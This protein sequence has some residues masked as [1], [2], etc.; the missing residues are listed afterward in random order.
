[1]NI[2]YVMRKCT[3]CGKW[4]VA[5]TVNFHRQKTGK[6]GLTSR[7]KECEKKLKKQWNEAN[8]EYY[9]QYRENNK[10]KIAIQK[11]EYRERNKEKIAAQQKERYEQNKDKILACNKKW[12][13]QNKDKVKEYR[14]EYA[15]LHKDEIRR[16]IANKI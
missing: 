6:Y 3:K 13:E 8:P 5:S 4:L 16:N 9:K 11:K 2:P 12:K 14:K 7:C 1:M 15:K 10:D